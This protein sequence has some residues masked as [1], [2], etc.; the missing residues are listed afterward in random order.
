MSTDYNVLIRNTSIVDGTG[1]RP[2]VGNVAVRG[3]RIVAVGETTGDASA[4]TVIDGS[5]LTTCPGFID[6][7]S[8]ADTSILEYPEADNLV[9]QGVTT[10]L[11]G[12]CGFSLAPIRDWPYFERVA[13]MWGLRLRP[14][15]RDFGSW[16]ERVS[17]EGISVNYAPLVGHNTV[18]GAVLG[19][20][21]R[22]EATADEVLAMKALIAEAMN[23]GAFGISV[24]LDAAWAGHF[25]S[26]DELVQA[27][28]VVQPYGGLFAPHTKHHQNQ[29]PAEHPS[30]FGYGIFHGPPGEIIVGRYHGLLQGAEISRKAGG[31]RLHIAHLTPAYLI[32]QP[33]PA[34]L[35]EVAARA[36]LQDVVEAAQDTGLDVTYNVVAWPFSIGTE[37]PIIK[38]F[39]GDRLLL[40]QWY[41]D[42]TEQEFIAALASQEF[43]QRIGQVVNSGRFKFG[44]IHPLTD[45]YWMDC[46]RVV[47]CKDPRYPGHTIGE[48]ARQRRPDDILGAVYDEA[49]NVV[50]D[51]LMA[52]PAAS[53]ALIMDKREYGAIE[54]FLKHPAGMPSSDVQALSARPSVHSGIYEYGV[55]PIAYGL[56]PR[57]FRVYVRE[58]GLLT[59]EQ[60]VHK[61][62]GLPAQRVLHLK[63]R[64]VLRPGAYADLVVFDPETIREEATLLEPTLPPRGIYHV[65]VNGTAVYREGRHT[66]Q[67]P[68]KV[69]KRS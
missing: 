14:D 49:L 9:M 29:W 35:D 45:P 17:R 25:A 8:H 30:D 46:Y 19:E 55:P 69:L 66:G 12:N 58:Q 28:S 22:R 26:S 47:R 4:A 48:I 24:G 7:H 10:F 27:V 6:I 44:M 53:W 51:V 40:P 67:R 50:L 13:R 39:F 3:E 31:V 20:D 65:F 59:L 41:R 54:V 52:D 64:G 33:H 38:S 21:F 37:V 36:T 1:S 16:L 15:W 11:G 68:G 63:D 56:F 18:R 61:V 60:A 43:R 23:S 62:T 32:P 5:G 42:M 2:F 57:Y 34:F